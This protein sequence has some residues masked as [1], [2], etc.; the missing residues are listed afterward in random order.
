[1]SDSPSR[2][3]WIC[4]TCKLKLLSS[5]LP[6]ESVTNNLHLEEIPVEVKCLNSLEHHLIAPHILF[7]KLCLPQGWQR[8]CHSPCVSVP[9]NNS[10]ITYIHPRNVMT[11]FQ[12]YDLNANCYTNL[13]MSINISTLNMSEVH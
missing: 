5:Q 11:R 1:M 10:D 4:H 2:K 13:T 9:I 3:L 12:E 8:A 7:M 6:Q